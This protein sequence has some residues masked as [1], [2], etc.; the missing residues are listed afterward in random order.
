MIYTSYFAKMKKYP[1]MEF[2]SIARFTPRGI[3]IPTIQDLVPAVEDV[4]NEAKIFE[5]IN[6]GDYLNKTDVVNI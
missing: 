1:D 2:F 3:H 6:R 5:E 4:F